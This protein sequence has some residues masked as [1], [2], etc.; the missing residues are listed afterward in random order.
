MQM[1]ETIGA[2]ATAL[3]AAQA[4]IGGAV[5]DRVNPAFKSKYADL[6]SVWDAWQQVGPAQG[7][8]VV[9]LPGE[10]VDGKVTLTTVLTH[11][12]GEWMRETLSIPVTKQDAQGYG[13]ALTYAR[14]YGLSALVGIAPED[15][16]GNASVKPGPRPVQN[17]APSPPISAEQLSAL[18]TILSENGRD[19]SRFCAHY[20][21]EALPDFPANKY[22]GALEAIARAVAVADAK[23]AKKAA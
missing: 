8:G 7:L 16:D 18:Q 19:V 5:K 12:S 21:I 10:M 15:D 3:A 23:N 1:S 17:E 6:S 9:Q 11:K 2:L 14:R 22:A 13:S 4:T 20:G